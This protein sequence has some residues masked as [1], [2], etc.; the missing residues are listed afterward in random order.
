MREVRDAI[1]LDRVSNIEFVNLREL[2]HNAIVLWVHSAVFNSISSEQIGA[3]VS[4]CACV[5]ARL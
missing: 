5:S 4:S 1:V 2:Y 3:R